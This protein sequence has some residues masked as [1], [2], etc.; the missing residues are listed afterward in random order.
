MTYHKP[1]LLEESVN[2]LNIKPEGIYV[3]LTFGGGGHSR[4]ILEKLGKK[5]RLYAF[6]QD[7]DAKA[8]AP[9]DPRF[10][11]I[12]ANSRF[13]RNFL[14]FYDIDF[15]DGILADL[16]ISSHQIDE[17]E[18]GFT[19]MQDTGLDMRMNR[20]AGLTAADVLNTWDADAL[21]RIFRE[22]GEI[23]GYRNLT[24]MIIRSRSENKFSDTEQFIRA[25]SSFVPEYQR[26]KILAKIF[27]AL[28]IE[29]NDEMSALREMLQQSS[30]A[31][32]A[33][34]RL[35]V[36]TYHSVE[37][38]IVKTYLKTGN[39]EGNVEKDFYGNI[40]RPFRMINRNV[41]V[42]SEAE[43]KVNPR[44]RSAKLRI[45]EKS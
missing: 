27:Q 40:H 41:I 31:L 9:V 3:D 30:G 5:G 32:R 25:I 16:G 29:V 11:F 36:L 24:G 44:A 43:I 45:V 7:I 14:R 37:D 20:G 35:V 38:R 13:L 12:H 19:F 6:D 22:Y 8:N 23:K 21:N 33:E 15:V 2:G 28:R 26:N 42:P 34:G 10:T 1:V 17:R 4:L 18:R 39:H